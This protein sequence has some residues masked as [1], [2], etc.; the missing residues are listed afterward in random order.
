MVRVL[1]AEAGRL[2]E[3]VAVKVQRKEL[4]KHSEAAQVLEELVVEEEPLVEAQVLEDV[5]EVES[6]VGALVLTCT[7]PT[8]AAIGSAELL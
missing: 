8:E 4:E 7:E 5:L 6:L 2:L 1:R 3:L